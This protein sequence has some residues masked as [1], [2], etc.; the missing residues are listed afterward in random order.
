MDETLISDSQLIMLAGDAAFSRGVQY[1]QQ[2]MVIHWDKSG[3]T[4]SADVEGSELYHVTLTLTKQGL[5]GGCNCPASEGIDFC[6]HCV[7]VALAFRAEQAKQA[8]RVEGDT[9]DRIHAYVESLDKPSLVEALLS[10]IENDPVLYQQWSLKADAALGVL[11]HKALKKRIT[12]AFPINRGLFR[13]SQ[14]SHYFSKAEAVIEQLAEQVPQ[15]P[16]VKSLALVD[17][18]LARMD[19]ALETIDD[20]GGF[21]FHCEHLLHTLH[22]KTVKRL[23]WPADKL[24]DYLYEKSFGGEEDRYPPIPDAYLDVLNQA[25]QNAYHERLQQALDELPN[26]TATMEWDDRYRLT[27]LREPLL[28]RAQAAG[29]LPAILALYQKTISDEKDCLEAAELCIAYE[30]WDQVAAWL[31]YAAEC[32]AKNNHRWQLERNRLEIRLKLHR[33]EADAAAEQ[34]WGIYQHTQQLEDYRQLVTLIEAHQLATDY[35][36]QACDWLLKC[37]TQPSEKMPFYQVQRAKDSLL[38]IY[39]HEGRL[40]DAQ[41]LCA[42]HKVSA[43]LLYQLAK[44]LPSPD[45]QIPLYLRL[46][47]LYVEQTNKQGYRQGIALLKELKKSLQTPAQYSAFAHMLTQLHSEFKAKR[48]FIKWLNEAFP[49]ILK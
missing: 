39:L 13:Y 20:S 10:L 31:T 29:D 33:G 37:I 5:S 16:S 41:A 36:Q 49:D 15:L 12:A 47:R 42:E 44:A 14:V 40:D 4:I 25:S 19:K 22:I 46:V 11:D 24:A 1:Y 48:N 2:G 34:Q 32:E 30:A 18:A 28:K 27:R 23:D 17:Y 8:Q 35:R 9:S 21:R 45:A 6:K 7:A 43:H 3:S 26:Q 38:E